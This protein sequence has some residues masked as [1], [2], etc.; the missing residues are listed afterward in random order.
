[1]KYIHNNGYLEP[2]PAVPKPDWDPNIHDNHDREEM[3]YNY[4]NWLAA[5]IPVA[6]GTTW[7]DRE[8]EEGKDF[9]IK[10]GRCVTGLSGKD[11]LYCV[12][13]SNDLKCKTCSVAYPLPVVEEKE[14]AHQTL[15]SIM[16][17]NDRHLLICKACDRSW[18]L[19]EWQSEGKPTDP[20]DIPRFTARDMMECWDKALSFE[21][22]DKEKYFKSLGIKLPD[23]AY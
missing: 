12:Q 1:M 8:Y 4:S 9:E 20:L 19:S 18:T 21:T 6:P 17:T 2:V 3:E 7:E 11:R 15:K 23:N 5:R 22:R 13:C 14:C 16:D 10:L